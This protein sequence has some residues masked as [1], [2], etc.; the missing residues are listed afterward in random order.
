METEPR[1]IFLVAN[2]EQMVEQNAD[3]LSRAPVAAGRVC[4]P[5]VCRAAASPSLALLLHPISPDPSHSQLPHPHLLP[6]HLPCSIPPPAAPSHIPLLHPISPA[7]SYSQLSHPTS[8]CPILFLAIPIPSPTHPQPAPALKILG[9]LP[10]SCPFPVHPVGRPSRL[11][12]GAESQ[13]QT[14]N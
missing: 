6:P 3:S 13:S 9:L 4:A 14:Y 10:G 12:F 1:K 11:F 7:P 8:P 2:A 5:Q